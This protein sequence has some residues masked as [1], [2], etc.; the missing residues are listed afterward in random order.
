MSNDFVHIFL[1]FS[2][3]SIS[4]QR[5][6]TFTMKRKLLIW[7]LLLWMAQTANAQIAF[8]FNQLEGVRSQ[9]LTDGTTL[10]ALPV[11]SKLSDM[12]A[13][14]MQATVDGKP[15]K[16]SELKPNPTTIN[17]DDLQI[18]TF[19]YKGKRQQFRFTV[20]A[21]FTAVVIS[22][23]HT[24]QTPLNSIENER[25]Y[26]ERIAL[27]GH[28]GG[29]QF[30]F[31][32]LPTY[33]PTADIVLFLGDMDKDSKREDT[34]FA[35][36]MSPFHAHSIPFVP[37]LGN[38]DF[39]SDFWTGNKPGYGLTITGGE[40]ANQAALKTIEAYLDSAKAVANPIEQLERITDGS[41]H[42]QAQPFTFVFHGVRF[43]CGHTYWYQKPYS[44]AYILDNGKVK[45]KA[46]YYAPDAV[47]E[48]LRKTVKQHQH[49]PSIWL[50]HYPFLSGDD[51][52]RWWLDQ[53]DVGLYLPTEDSSI[54]GTDRK[55]S[56]FTTDAAKAFA[57]QKKDTLVNIIAMTKNPVH[58][59]GHT[60]FFDERTYRNANSSA[61]VKDYTV[62]AFGE[63]KGDAYILL[64]KE[65][66]GCI[67]IKK[68]NFGDKGEKSITKQGG[69]FPLGVAFGSD[70][71]TIRQACQVAFGEPDYAD[72][73]AIIYHHK[74]YRGHE[75]AYIAFGIQYNSAGEGFYNQ[76]TMMLSS[77]PHAD[78]ANTAIEELFTTVKADYKPSEITKTSNR[79][80]WLQYTGGKDP[81]DDDNV[82]FT[83][84]KDQKT[85]AE[86]GSVNYTPYI[87]YGP[88]EFTRK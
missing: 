38:H 62:S 5:I 16:L 27:M 9:T 50:Q 43:Y 87:T 52:D 39:V 72:S 26:C 51:C 17:I 86:T 53:T 48:A 3:F 78:V 20:G 22:D 25:I 6:I 12:A 81:T 69:R 44:G 61:E 56:H 65:G 55:I 74:N 84:A 58:F 71:T 45:E 28:E 7:N 36:A 47:I 15:V 8:S 4:S 85:D 46:R 54:Y 23:S 10:V 40:P 33:L 77:T 59:S 49:E 30:A 67:E 83:V 88:F 34:E 42:T 57:R 80:G 31:D 37:M 2:S 82:F 13:Y 35:A 75:F 63:D 32:T 70:Y 41:G 64:C 14:G 18:T 68:A 21:Y 11:G 24:A 60:H 79:Y 76:C 73:T 29:A 66:V 19:R 1:S